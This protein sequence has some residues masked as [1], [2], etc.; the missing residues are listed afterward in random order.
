[1]ELQIWLYLVSH[2][3]D[4]LGGD[5]HLSSRHLLPCQNLLAKAGNINAIAITTYNINVLTELSGCDSG[6]LTC[7][8]PFLFQQ[9]TKI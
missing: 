3:T 6:R 4:I 5:T 9:S 8:E 7:T 1:M 2:C